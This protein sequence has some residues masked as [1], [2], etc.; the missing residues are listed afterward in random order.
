MTVRDQLLAL[1]VP[2]RRVSHAI[3]YM[4]F[5]PGTVDPNAPG[6]IEIVR[7][8]QRRLRSGGSPLGLTGRIDVATTRALD[9]A[10][11]PAGTF[12]ARSFSEIASVLLTRPQRS[13][14][15]AWG[16]GIDDPR[17]CV[18]IGAT[19]KTFIR[20]QQGINRLA[21][22]LG[23][24]RVGVDGVLG[25]TSVVAAKAAANKIY[26][27]PS[28]VWASAT[29]D[30]LANNAP[31]I[32]NSFHEKADGLG[33]P[34]SAPGKWSPSRPGTPGPLAPAS[35][36]SASLLPPSSVK[37]LPFVLIAGGVAFIAVK[38]RPGREAS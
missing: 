9:A 16:R 22:K 27:P 13:A 35:I 17:N 7:A 32:A 5:A 6:V 1:G 11:P 28:A 24:P 10:V 15:G 19:K 2:T 21:A 31:A 37:V 20:L 36:A 3:P 26:S 12:S 33:A 38:T 29:C 18:G 8:I 23:T 30:T 4:F 34:K 25:P 14:M